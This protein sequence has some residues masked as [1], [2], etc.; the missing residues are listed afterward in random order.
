MKTLYLAWQAPK[1]SLAWFPIGRLDANPQERFYR[2]RYIQGARTAEAEGGLPVLPA[3]PV[4]EQDYY[5]TQ[6]FPLFE[7]RVMNK[8]RTDFGDYLQSLD[9]VRKPNQDAELDLEMLSVTGGQ[10]LTDDLHVFPKITPAADKT[11]SLRFFLHGIRHL[12]AASQARVSQLQAGESLMVGVELNNPATQLAI[13]LHTADYQMLGWAPR[14][15]VNDILKTTPHAP[16]LEVK[17]VRLN[18][19]GMVP[20]NR[21]VLVELHGKFPEGIQPMSG[22]EFEPLVG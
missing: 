22:P 12:N 15:L 16:E 1:P 10:R 18:N 7:N 19:D 6:L 3:F 21:R 9:L 4:F 13:N 17:V 5:S 8:R 20:P 14:Y 2:F 11:F